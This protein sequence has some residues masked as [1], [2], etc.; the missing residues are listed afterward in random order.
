MCV[1]LDRNKDLLNFTYKRLIL[2]SKYPFFLLFLIPLFLISQENEKKT[3][4]YA[5]IKNEGQWHQDVYF[6]TE[7]KEASIFFT[8]YGIRYQFIENPDHESNH[9]DEEKGE[10][11]AHF[12]N[13]IFIGAN[14]EAKLTAVNA[15]SSYNNYYLGKDK[16]KWKTGVYSYQEMLLENIYPGIDIRY[17]FK[18][19]YLKYD[20]ILAP[21]ADPKLIKIK[22]DGVA[23]PTIS[24]GNLIVEHAFGTLI[25]KAPIAFQEING[26]IRSIDCQFVMNED[27]SIQFQ[28]P[29]NYASENALIIDP[30][31]VFSTYSGSNTTNFGMTATYD[32]SGNGYMGG[33]IF[34]NNYNNTI[35]GYQQNFGGG[36]VDIVIS[37]FSDDGTRLLYNTF[38]GGIESEAVASMVVNSNEE[39]IVLAITSS[40]DYPITTGSY[41]TQ[42][43]NSVGVILNNYRQIYS[44]GNDI[45]ISKFSRNGRNLLASTFFGGN[46]SDGL[47]FNSSNIPSYTNLVY[48]YG[49]HFRGEITVD[50]NDTIYIGTST[51]SSNLDT[52]LS[53]FS[54]LQEGLIVKF[55]PNLDSLIWTRYLGGAA[56]DAIYSLKVTDRNE[57]L[58]GGGTRSFTNFPTTT[59]AYAT[60]SFGG[61]ADG[62]MTLLSSNGSILYSTFLGSTNYDQAYFVE[63]DRFN[64]FYAFGQTSNPNYPIVNSSIADTGACQFIMKL[65]STLSNVEFSHTFGNGNNIGRINISPTAFLVDRCLNIYTSGWGG[66]IQT[67]EGAKTLYPNMP[68]T[69]NAE[70]S[71]T[72][73]NDFYFYVINR[74]LDSLVYASFLG[75]LSSA[76]HLSIY[77]RI[78]LHK[79]RFSNKF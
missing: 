72:D 73:R 5:F 1:Y 53:Q 22:Y 13:S 56:D 58:V 38:L 41:K 75:G 24:E 25:E 45:A 60:S 6:K 16:S 19:G 8:N 28:F 12:F 9:A 67:G 43:T 61:T 31:L 26:E 64:N 20:F 46:S 78:L 37:K 52:S 70:Q 34:E 49:D 77:L 62:F 63:S 21:Y 47:N 39:L 79:F 57:I 23:N 65:D 76:Y 7:L 42:K 66:S 32:N 50:E 29:E 69:A 33:T 4:R 10:I 14:P 71:T 59:N 40:A 44:S 27:N 36:D 55:S 48:N 51:H 18:D 30:Q 17:Y 2:L 15:S 74:D 35:N 3:D 11:E 54:G 68:L